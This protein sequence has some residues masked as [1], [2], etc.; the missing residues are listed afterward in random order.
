MQSKFIEKN[1]LQAEIG[2]FKSLK[3]E[4]LKILNEFDEFSKTHD[5]DFNVYSIGKGQRFMEKFI[6]VAKK[7]CDEYNQEYSKVN[8]LLNFD[9]YRG[10]QYIS[11][12]LREENPNEWYSALHAILLAC[13]KAIEGLN[14]KISEFEYPIINLTKI[15]EKFLNPLKF[16]LH[17]FKEKWFTMSNPLVWLIF[18]LVLIIISYFIYKILK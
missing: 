5:F 6:K 2:F 17:F 4:T 14:A 9:T 12:P 8:E 1:K 11:S 16:D 15:K 10:L 3:E 13:N 7:L 18:S